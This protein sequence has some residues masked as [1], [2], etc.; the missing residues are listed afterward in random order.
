MTRGFEGQ[1]VRRSTGSCGK[2]RKEHKGGDVIKGRRDE[3]EIRS[4]TNNDRLCSRAHLSRTLIHSVEEQ[5]RRRRQGKV[6]YCAITNTQGEEKEE[7]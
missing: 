2:K 1:P 6:P 5:R 7:K 4:Q 3:E